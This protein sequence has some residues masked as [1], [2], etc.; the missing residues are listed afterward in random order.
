MRHQQNPTAPPTVAVI[1]NVATNPGPPYSETSFQRTNRRVC[2]IGT[3][4][5]R[6]GGLGL[7]T[8]ALARPLFCFFGTFCFQ[9]CSVICDWL[10]PFTCRHTEQE[11][12]K[13]HRA[14]HSKQEVIGPQ[15]G[16]SRQTGK[17]GRVY[18]CDVKANIR[19][20][21]S[22]SG[23]AHFFCSSSRSAGVGSF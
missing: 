21:N 5:A 17:K 2:C 22:P 23:F 18:S 7:L 14:L 16:L 3:V 11:A 8:A 6:A 13:T 19:I 4:Y 10:I 15:H 9:F 12:V 20:T 1:S